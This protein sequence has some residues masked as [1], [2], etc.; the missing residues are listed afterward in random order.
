MKQESEFQLSAEHFPDGIACCRAVLDTDGKPVDFTFLEV[1]PAFERLTGLSRN[2]VIGK[3]TS[4]V[5]PKIGLPTNNWINLCSKA[6]LE[7][8][9][10]RLE[11]YLKP[12]DCWYEIIAYRD[13]KDIV[14]TIF[15]NITTQK[16]DQQTMS[17]T[18]PEGDIGNLELSDILDIPA[19]Q[20]LMTD[21]YQFTKTRIGLFDVQGR[22]L[23]L[24][25]H[26][27]ICQK[28]HRAHPETAGTAWKVIPSSP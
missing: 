5:L 19:L 7:E 23:V 11:Q 13:Q 15:R 16:K 12:L 20:S 18:T 2:R 3:W 22:G 25:G 4:E 17:T 10:T 28:F 9:S 21:F 1:N 6:L 14:V 24:T 26:Q 27:E 8:E